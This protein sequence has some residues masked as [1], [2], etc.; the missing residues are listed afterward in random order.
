MCT[1]TNSNFHKFCWMI[2]AH[3]IYVLKLFL[4]YHNAMDWKGFWESRKMIVQ[5]A[6]DERKLIRLNHKCYIKSMLECPFPS[7]RNLF[8]CKSMY[9]N[10]LPWARNFEPYQFSFIIWTIT[11]ST[12][13]FSSTYNAMGWNDFRGSIFYFLFLSFDIVCCKQSHSDKILRLAIPMI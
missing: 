6:K 10:I 8:W 7:Y 2:R 5:C 1:F 9:Q 4:L 12:P 11:I 13:S 3:C